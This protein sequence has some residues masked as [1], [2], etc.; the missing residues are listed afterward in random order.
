MSK[1]LLASF[2]NIPT[3][4]TSPLLLI[5]LPLNKESKIVPISLGHS[6]ISTTATGLAQGNGKIFIAF[7]S[8]GKFRVAVLDKNLNSLFTQELESQ[9]IHSMLVDGKYLYTISTGTD[10][11]VRYE[12][13][14]K[15]LKTPEVVWRA[16]DIKKENHHLNSITKYKGDLIISSFGKSKMENAWRTAYDGII[17]NVTKGIILKDKVYQPHSVSSNGEDLFYCESGKGLFL[18]T[19]KFSK[20]LD[21]YT[22][23]VQFESKT[24]VFVATSFGR[25]PKRNIKSLFFNPM[26]SG[27]KSGACRIYNINISSKKSSHTDFGWF[28]NEIYDLLIL[29]AK[30]DTDKLFMSSF[31]EERKQLSHSVSDSQRFWNYVKSKIK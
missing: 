18:S 17:F 19:N 10:E 16:S 26:D 31:L 6:G 7:I 27:K 24:S 9:D 8:D 30:L 29:D 14:N 23:G 12:I 22:R 13:T 1:Y 2:C 11:V 25:S 5:S 4:T 20:S 3:P 15:E 21:G 28:A